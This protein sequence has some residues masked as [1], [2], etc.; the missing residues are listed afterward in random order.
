M[1]SERSSHGEISLQTDIFFFSANFPFKLLAAT[2]I[3][4]PVTMKSHQNPPYSTE[5]QSFLFFLAY[6]AFFSIRNLT[7]C[8]FLENIRQTSFL[9]ITSSYSL[10]TFLPHLL[11][12]S[13]DEFQRK[14]FGVSWEFQLHFYRNSHPLEKNYQTY[15][16]WEHNRS[17]KERAI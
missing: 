9:V 4:L 2:C 6:Y 15:L 1:I 10:C 17:E 12:K 13:A 5:Q 14:F 8:C 7:L 16:N 3:V 11:L